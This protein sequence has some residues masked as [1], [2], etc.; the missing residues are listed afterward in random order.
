MLL[1]IDVGN[2]NAEIGLFNLNEVTGVLIDHFRIE[3]RKTMTSDELGVLIK[4]FLFHS[5]LA[6]SDIR[7]IICSSV[8]PQ[9]NPS[10]SK[11]AEKYFDCSAVFVSYKMQL[12]LRFKYPNPAEIGADRIVNAVAVNE[13]YGGPAII[14]DFGT[15]T[16]FCVLNADQEYLGGVISPGILS[17]LEFLTSK[18][19]KLPKIELK[20]P[21]TI[22]GTST[23]HAMRSGVYFGTIEKMEGI[24]RR[25]RK[26]TGL[27]NT[28]VIATGGFSQMVAEGT[29]VIDFVDQT[30]TLKGLEILFHKNLPE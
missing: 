12:G 25:L 4:S 26:E 22:L 11:M 6:T 18:T 15:A 9:L 28:R 5:R 29:Q 7:G 13:I 19:A 17:S 14:V 16:T 24:I 3:T 27:M 2:T 10:I 8:V 30:L 21:E 1:S 20:R 23:I